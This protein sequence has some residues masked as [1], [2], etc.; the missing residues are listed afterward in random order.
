MTNT[1]N[2]LGLGH[3]LVICDRYGYPNQ[4]TL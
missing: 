3:S 1:Y 2:G 4:G